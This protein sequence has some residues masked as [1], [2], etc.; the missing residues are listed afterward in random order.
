M[1]FRDLESFNQALLAKAKQVWRILQHP[2]CLMAH[3]IKARYFPEGAILTEVQRKKAPYAW[4]SLL[5]GI[6]LL[7]QGMRF[8]IGQGN[9]VNMWKHALLPEHHRGYLVH[10]L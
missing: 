10:Y 3:V 8:V 7:K 1:G 9:T 4:K 6:D 2:E 5:Y